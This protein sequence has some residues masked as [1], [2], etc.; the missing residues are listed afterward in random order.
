MNYICY[1]QQNP[2][3]TLCSVLLQFMLRFI[4]KIDGLNNFDLLW[5]LNNC[6]W[7]LRFRNP[8]LKCRSWWVRTEDRRQSTSIYFSS[9][10]GR[11]CSKHGP[12]SQ[13]KTQW[14]T[15]VSAATAELNTLALAVRLVT[16]GVKM[17]TQPE[18]SKQASRR[19]TLPPARSVSPFTKTTTKKTTANG[20]RAR[21]QTITHPGDRCRRT[22]TL[23]FVTCCHELS[24]KK[25]H[26]EGKQRAN[27]K[28][29]S[30]RNR[31]PK[32]L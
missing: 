20:A 21:K 6:C 8:Y 24:I 23:P 9:G 19:V 28:N 17:N 31:G 12:W 27:T 5:I 16:L 22:L 32:S 18:T 25:S 3:Q 1:K 11:W 4:S 7:N 14:E 26:S 30:K 2:G 13:V 15:K 10:Y 29:D